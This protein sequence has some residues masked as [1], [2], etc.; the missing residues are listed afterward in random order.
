MNRNLTL[1]YP[2]A[3]KALCTALF[4]QFVSFDRTKQSCAWFSGLHATL[5]V[6][7]S[8]QLITATVLLD[9]GFFM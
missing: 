9:N 8:V 7:Y 3:V 1:L 5:Y 4:S 6:P 2:Q